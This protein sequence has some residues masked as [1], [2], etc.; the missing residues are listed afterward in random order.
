MYEHRFPAFKV[1]KY[2]EKYYNWLSIKYQ[3]N[4]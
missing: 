1:E 2:I 3:Y 4:R